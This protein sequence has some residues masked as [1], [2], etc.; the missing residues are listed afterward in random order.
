MARRNPFAMNQTAKEWSQGVGIMDAVA[1]LAGLY[2]VHVI[3]S[4]IVKTT[5]TVTNKAFKL[6]ADIAVA[7]GAGALGKATVGATFGKAAVLGGLAGAAADGLGMFAKFT[8]LARKI[9]ET[10]LISPPANREGETV[11]VIEP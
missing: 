6:A 3:P 4:M 9:G 10:T 2:M 11:S 1:A 8:P 5:D 7:V